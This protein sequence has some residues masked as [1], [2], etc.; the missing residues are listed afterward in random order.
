MIDG[1]FVLCSMCGDGMEKWKVWLLE[2]KRMMMFPGSKQC[3]RRD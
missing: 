2:C 1:E 3:G